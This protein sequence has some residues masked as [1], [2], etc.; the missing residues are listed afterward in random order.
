MRSCLLRD[1][2]AIDIDIDIYLAIAAAHASHAYV[3]MHN[4]HM[5]MHV[6]GDVSVYAHYAYAPPYT[7]A[8]FPL[9]ALSWSASYVL[10]NKPPPNI[11]LSPMP[12]E[13]FEKPCTLAR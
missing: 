12:G 7:R 9:G 1:I 8:Q 5:H 11:R 6:H 2:V 3:R 13:P 4:L 10:K